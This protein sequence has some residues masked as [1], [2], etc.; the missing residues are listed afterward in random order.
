M[1]QVSPVTGHVSHVTCHMSHVTWH[2]HFCSPFFFDKVVML[3]SWGFDINRVTPFSFNRNILTV[4]TIRGSPRSKHTLHRPA[5]TLC[6]KNYNNNIVTLDTWQLT[7]DM[8]RVTYDMWH[9]T[10]GGEWTFFQNFSSPAL[11]VWDKQYLEDFKR[12]YDLL[13]WTKVIVEQPRLH[14]VCL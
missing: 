2:R 13:N 7:C 4:L 8:W 3:V 9:V 12:K 6:K 14:G 11:T 10:N 5:Q 1:C